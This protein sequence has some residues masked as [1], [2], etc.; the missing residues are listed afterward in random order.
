MAGPA[1][2]LVPVENDPLQTSPGR[3]HNARERTSFE[4]TRSD[5]GGIVSHL[6]LRWCWFAFFAAALTMIDASPVNAELNAVIET[7][8]QEMRRIEAENW[9]NTQLTFLLA[10]IA[11]LVFYFLAKSPWLLPSKDRGSKN[12]SNRKDAPFKPRSSVDLRD[13][14]GKP[15]I[16]KNKQMTRDEIEQEFAKVSEANY[17]PVE[18][19]D[20]ETETL[21]KIV[22]KGAKWG[23]VAGFL[24]ATVYIQIHT[25][26]SL[27]FYTGD[28]GLV[29]F[30]CMGPGAAI[31]ALFAW[32]G[33]LISGDRY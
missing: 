16:G 20:D 25:P 11:I 12:A 14:A 33:T 29:F 10:G 21:L 31:G 2:G 17:R 3:R 30:A 9:W 28:V 24:V 26:S 32:L 1:A 15:A 13:A 27:G 22:F 18:D 19:D 23:F 6:V 7:G 4:K 8:A 5:M